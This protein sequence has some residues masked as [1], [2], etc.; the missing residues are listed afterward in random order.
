V[1]TAW[2]QTVKA[3]RAAGSMNFTMTIKTACRRRDP[4]NW[5]AVGIVLDGDFATRLSSTGTK[6]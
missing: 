4:K 3:R 6:V 1:D 5:L 2:I